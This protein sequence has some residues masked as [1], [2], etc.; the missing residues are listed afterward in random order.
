MFGGAP[1]PL[2]P[3]VALRCGLSVE[4]TESAFRSTGEGSALSPTTDSG[5]AVSSYGRA[6]MSY[7]YG[8]FAA[9]PVPTPIGGPCCSYSSRP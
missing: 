4:K 9:W 3:G 8:G 5:S 2:S 1:M 6:G 7:G